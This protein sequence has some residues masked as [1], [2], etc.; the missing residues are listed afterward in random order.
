MTH[1]NDDQISDDATRLIA[2]TEDAD[3][4]AHYMMDMEFPIQVRIL[5]AAKL[6]F[7][8]NDGGRSSAYHIE[9]VCEH[10]EEPYKSQASA[11]L[12]DSFQRPH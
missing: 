3:V 1:F 8:W 10:G 9:Y 5:A 11:I 2:S 7:M 4:L 6:I 12:K